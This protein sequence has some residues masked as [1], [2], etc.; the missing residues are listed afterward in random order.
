[1]RRD[2]TW[3]SRVLAGADWFATPYLTVF[4]EQGFATDAYEAESP[5]VDVKQSARST[6]VSSPERKVFSTPRHS[7]R[8]SSRLAS[9]SIVTRDEH[10]APRK[11]NASWSKAAGRLR[12][13]SRRSG[14]SAAG[15]RSSWRRGR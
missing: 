1:M 3:H 14:A 12:S 6:S 11:T 15:K 2:G 8:G 4:L 9:V 5:L 13:P 10:S 7:T